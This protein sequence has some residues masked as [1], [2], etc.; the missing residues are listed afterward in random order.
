M[1]VL[2]MHQH[3]PIA[4]EIA[5]EVLKDPSCRIL[6]ICNNYP[7]AFPHSTDADL[8]I[9]GPSSD[10]RHKPYTFAFNY[11]TSYV[12]DQHNFEPI[13]E[14]NKAVLVALLGDDCSVTET[15]CFEFGFD[16]VHQT[17]NIAPNN[18]MYWISTARMRKMQYFS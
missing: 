3:P 4:R 7:D 1:N 11:L 2:I 17:I 5:R 14:H 13:P 10:Q 15:R 18:F 16:F 9:V 6:P 12:T 8:I